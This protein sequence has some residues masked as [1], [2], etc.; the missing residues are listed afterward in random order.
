MDT[1]R[2]SRNFSGMHSLPDFLERNYDKLIE[3]V[4]VVEYSIGLEFHEDVKCLLLKYGR[5]PKQHEGPSIHPPFNTIS[6]AVV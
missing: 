2:W 4:Q 1:L 5:T 3:I 6:V